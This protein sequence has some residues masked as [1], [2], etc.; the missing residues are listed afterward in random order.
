M[1]KKVP[2]KHK[3]QPATKAKPAASRGITR[4]EAIV[5]ATIAGILAAQAAKYL[6]G[7]T[8]TVALAPALPPLTLSLSAV[9]G[10]P[11]YPVQDEKV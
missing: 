7:P 3:K 4:R 9:Y 1:S 6:P 2:K 10:K 8:Q 11:Y 5:D